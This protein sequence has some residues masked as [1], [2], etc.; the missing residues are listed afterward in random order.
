MTEKM[1]AIRK[2]KPAP[3][4]ELQEIEI[5]KPGKDELLIKVEACSMCGTDIHIY[6]WEPPWSTGR[7]VPP[8]TLGHEVCGTVIEK[9]KAVTNI[10]I[11]DSVSAESHIFC[12]ACD[13]CK[14]GNA[15]ICENLKF[16]SIDTDGFFAPYAILPVQNAWKNPKNMKH[17]IAT[18]QESMGNSVYTVS[19]Q[20]VKDKIMAV[21]GCGPTGLF[22]IGIARSMGAAKIIAVAG[23][24]LHMKIA[25]KMGADVIINRHNEDPIKTIMDGTD[26]RGV[27]VAL[28]MSGAPE[29][30]NQALKVVRPVGSVA[31][32]GLPTKDVTIDVSK[33]IVLKDLTFRGIYGRKIWDTWEITSQ[34]LKS[35]LDISPIITHRLKLENF[36]EGIQAMKSGQ[37]GK[38]VMR[39]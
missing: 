32:L 4:L 8:K 21:F 31:V 10:D 28:E 24:D 13:Q 37:C 35:G 39:P 11:G 36:E 17:E 15:H 30:L 12:S 19:S 23:T 38:V 3:G 29:A 2:I 9:G 27:D 18:L 5:P 7:F 14:R 6:N 33:L 34:L 16:F 20:N 26:G 22:A 25:K 1:I